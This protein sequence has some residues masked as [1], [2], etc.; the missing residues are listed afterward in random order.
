MDRCKI[1]SCGTV[2]PNR[3]NMPRDSGL[4][5]LKLKRGDVRVRPTGGLT[6]LVWKEIQEVYMLTNT[7]PPP[8][9]VNF[10]DDSNHTV[11]LHT[12]ERYNQHMGYVDNSKCMA[13]R[14]LVSR[15]T[16]KWTT[17]LFFHRLDLRVLHSWILLFSCGAKYTHQDLGS[18]C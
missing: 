7:D 18:F 13:N 3:K 14:Y 15:R 4:K 8:Q 2:L 10:C 5:Q 16:F 9:E 12:V 1:N 6:A 17:K 11:K